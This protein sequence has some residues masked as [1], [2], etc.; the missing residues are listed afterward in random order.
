M[1]RIPVALQLYSVRDDMKEDFK[2]TLR[3]V[4]EMGYDG[5]EFAGLFENSAEDVKKMCEEIGL[6]PISAHVSYKEMME[7]ETTIDRYKTIGCEYIVI[8]SLRKENLAG[9][10]FYTQTLEGVKKLGEKAK[11][12]GMKLGYHNH[13][14]EF[15]KHDGKYLLDAL[16]DDVSKDL[17]DTQLDTCWVNVGGENPSEYIRK[18]ADRTNIIHLKDFFGSKTENMYGLI[19]EKDSGKEA[20]TAKFDYLPV[21]YGKQDFVSIMNA[22]HEIGAKWVVVEQ[23]KPSLDKTPL[24]CAKMSVDYIKPLL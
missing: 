16:Y 7:D 5:V 11:A 10:E 9:G 1:S 17:L 15:A 20:D 3:K 21:G 12:A 19:S 6:T 18:Y 13:D 24:E 14:F 4:K 22:A 23:D 2:G 8:P